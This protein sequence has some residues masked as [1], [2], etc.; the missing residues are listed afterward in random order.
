MKIF[1]I[2]FFDTTTAGKPEEIAQSSCLSFFAL[3]QKSKINEILRF[4]SSTIMNK[5]NTKNVQQTSHIS[6]TD[7][8]F[9][10]HVLIDR[11]INISGALIT[12]NDYPAE[13]AYRVISKFLATTSIDQ[14]R[15]NEA[16]MCIQ[17]SQMMTSILHEFQNPSAD[18]I[19]KIKQDVEESKLILH[20]VIEQVM[21][22]GEKLD[23]LIDKTNF[24]SENS[25]SFYKQSKKQARYCPWWL[26][27]Y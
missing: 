9:T 10:I 15:R 23:D 26:P 5:V 11:S 2:S 14:C 19:Y 12:D 7:Q 16:A 21:E 6:I 13:V 24:L 4:I 8:G 18:K 27:F 1:H 3:T 20:K 17:N 25:K 22:R